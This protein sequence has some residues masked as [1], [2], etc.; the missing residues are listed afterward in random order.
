MYNYEPLTH[1]KNI[2]ATCYGKYI[3]IRGTVVRVSN[4][5]PLCIKMAF[6]C[7]ACGEIQ[8]FPLPDGKYNLPTKVI[9]SLID[10]IFCLLYREG[11]SAYRK[12]TSAFEQSCSRANSHTHELNTTRLHYLSWL[13]GIEGWKNPHPGHSSS[14][15]LWSYH[16]K[17]DLVEWGVPPFSCLVLAFHTHYQSSEFI[18]YSWL[19]TTVVERDQLVGRMLSVNW[20][21]LLIGS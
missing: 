16:Y 1:L 2:R 14:V 15:S 13:P 10:H 11:T 17:I 3:S 12:F 20:L 6:Q 7:A 8:S 5:K 4:I 9:C 21:L 18:V 19:L